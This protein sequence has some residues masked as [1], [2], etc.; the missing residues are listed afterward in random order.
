MNNLTLNIAN[1]TEI[2]IYDSRRKQ[3]HM[4]P[5]LPGITRVDSLHILY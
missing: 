3:P 1:T 2:L 5:P 4:P